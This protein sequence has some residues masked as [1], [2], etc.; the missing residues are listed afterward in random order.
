MKNSDL[1]IKPIYVSHYSD[2]FMYLFK[3][4][5]KTSENKCSEIENTISEV[6]KQENSQI[7]YMNKKI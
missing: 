5:F 2:V 6:A 4:H 1:N 7:I 3:Y